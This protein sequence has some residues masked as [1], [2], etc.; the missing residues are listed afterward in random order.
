M[1]LGMIAPGDMSDA[2]RLVWDAFPIGRPVDF[3]TGSAED[4]DPAGGEGWG[5]DRQIR[6]EVLAALLC[7][8]V[9]VEPGQAAGIYLRRVRVAGRL[10]LPSAIL[11]HRLSL[12]NCYVADGID[13]AEAT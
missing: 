6:A 9:E 11:K 7:G 12:T 13:L 10:E 1:M 5:L 2:E 8:A 4:D 3:G